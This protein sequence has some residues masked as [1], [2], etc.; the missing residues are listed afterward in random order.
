MQDG[1]TGLYIAAHLGH[2]EVVRALL[3]QGAD[4]EVAD[5]VLALIAL[6]SK[7]VPSHPRAQ[8]LHLKFNCTMFS[9]IPRS[10]TLKFCIYRKVC[11]WVRV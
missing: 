7:D 8:A 10:K 2:L 1:N 3:E 4:T 11:N 6:W 9:V 5:K